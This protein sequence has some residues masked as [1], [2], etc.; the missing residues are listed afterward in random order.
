MTPKKML[1]CEVYIQCFLCIN[2]L[3][4]IEGDNQISNFLDLEIFCLFIVWKSYSYLKVM[5]TCHC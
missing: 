2:A 1:I 3:R 4:N 5:L